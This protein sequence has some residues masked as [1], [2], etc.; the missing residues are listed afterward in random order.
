MDQQQFAYMLFQG[1]GRAYLHLQAQHTAVYHETLLT[2]CR[3]NPVYDAQCEGS[4]THYYYELLQLLPDRAWYEHELLASLADPD[5][6]MDVDQLFELAGIFARQG[7]A[8]ARQVIYESCGAYA[9]LGW[10]TGAA[11]LIALDGF[12]GFLFIA[13]RL[14]EALPDEPDPWDVRYLLYDMEDQL[15]K[16]TVQHFLT[17]AQAKH[18]FVRRYLELVE[19]AKT[20]W[21]Q[22]VR[23]SPQLKQASYDAVKQHLAEITIRPRTSYYYLT[24]WG[25][26]AAEEDILRAA[27]DLIQQ[28]T[29]PLLQAY[30]AMFHKRSFPLDYQA[31]V[32]LVWHEDAM[33]ARWAIRSL[34]PLRAAAIRQLGLELIEQNYYVSE[35]IELF[36]LNFEPGDEHLFATIFSRT[37]D[38]E[39]LHA[40]GMCMAQVFEANP[41]RAA[42][43]VL[44]QLYE[45]G[46][47]SLCRHRVVKLL[48]DMQAAPDWLLAECRYDVDTQTRALAIQHRNT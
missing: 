27:H 10:T 21:N 40:L 15:G 45:R 38:Q 22:T 18:P 7:N 44:L 29:I 20:Q 17:E 26:A 34:A 13:E 9:T 14:G 46:P 42:V 4:R 33:V 32:P 37:T 6:E 19:R 48:V 43:P 2:A 36:K 5:D 12:D 11:E 24:R 47:C 39:K 23:G 30:L 41:T 8:A 1:R 28:T 3:Y 25:Q 35:A 16:E 31:V